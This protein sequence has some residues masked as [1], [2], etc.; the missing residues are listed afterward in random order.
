[1]KK[2][3]A[4]L[5]LV[6]AVCFVPTLAQAQEASPA[7]DVPATA[8]ATA[9]ADVLATVDTPASAPVNEVATPPATVATTAYVAV[10]PVVLPVSMHQEYHPVVSE[11]NKD[12]FKIGMLFDISVPSGLAL[13]VE[14]RAPHVPWFKLGFAVTETLSPGYRFNL[15]IDPIKFGIAPVGNIELGHQTQFSIPG[16]D[17]SPKI[18]FTYYDLQGGIGLGS[19]DGFRFL[20]LTGM[21]HLAGAAHNFQGLVGDPVSGLT[22]NDP[23][24]SGWIPSAKIGINYLF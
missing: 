13:G 6:S 8:G 16:V 4:F 2:F 18:N 23:T 19:R 1:M 11:V 24:F 21:S 22:I 15:L 12:P 5:T 9:T 14:A 10:P 7:V 17:N 20:L 3:I